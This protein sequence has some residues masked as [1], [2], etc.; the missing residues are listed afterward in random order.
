MK[1]RKWLLGHTTVYELCEYKNLGVLKNYANSFSTNVEDNIEKARKKAEMIFACNFDRRKTKPLIYIK[2]WREACLPSLF[3]G[4]ELFSL[5][6][7]QLNQLERCQQWFFK[8]IFYIPQFAPVKFLLKVSG[9]NSVESEIDVKKLL[10]LGRLITETKMASA[11][12]GI[13]FSRVDSFFEAKYSALGV[14][15]SICEALHKYDL[16][17]HFER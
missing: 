1:E 7:T 10:F 15:P 17:H 12:K 14:L 6:T 3:F 11:V 9:L 8:K 16:F 4:A 5:T 13:F 2:F